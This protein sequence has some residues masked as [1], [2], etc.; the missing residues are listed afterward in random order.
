[1]RAVHEAGEGFSYQKRQASSHAA[2]AGT[3]QPAANGPLPSS[4]SCSSRE[5]HDSGLPNGA[6]KPQLA[7]LQH[8]APV[9]KQQQQQA[10]A[11]KRGVVDAAKANGIHV[12]AG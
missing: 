4:S 8:E 3:P 11:L 7:P 6:I 2:A 5:A 9:Q 1:M 12:S 10:A